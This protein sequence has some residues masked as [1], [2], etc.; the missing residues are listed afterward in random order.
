[1]DELE[2]IGRLDTKPNQTME[3]LVEKY[4]AL[5]WHI[6]SK[7]LFNEE[8]IKECV[9]DTFAEVYVH[10]AEYDA[11][12][13]SLSMWIGSISRH[14][15]ISMYR[16][17]KRDEE[18]SR[19]IASE[20]ETIPDVQDKMTEAEQAMD[21]KEA[22]AKLS[23]IDREVICMKYYDGMSISEIAESLHI[24]YETAK[25]RHTRSIKNLRK[26]LLL[27]LLLLAL[28]A[29]VACGIIF[30]Y[31]HFRVLP[32]IGITSEEDGTVYVLPEP[33]TLQKGMFTVE[34]TKAAVY[35]DFLTVAYSVSVPEQE[36]CSPAAADEGK[37]EI[38][39]YLNFHGVILH[40][41]GSDII[42]DTDRGEFADEKAEAE[43]FSKK[44]QYTL[45]LKKREL[46]KIRADEQ[47]EFLLEVQAI[48][49]DGEDYETIELPF[50]LVKTTAEKLDNYS[51]F[52]DEKT[53]GLLLNTTL[54][55]GVLSMEVYPLA[56][57]N[58][59]YYVGL[60]DDPYRQIEDDAPIAIRNEEGKV[61][62]AEPKRVPFGNQLNNYAIY[63]FNDIK[64]GKY[65]L[66]LPYVY[67]L[68]YRSGI[69]WAG[70]NL[71][72]CT[73]QE[74]KFAF[75]GGSM[76][77]TGIRESEVSDEERE[78]GICDYAWEISIRCEMQDEAMTMA[79]LP[80]MPIKYNWKILPYIEMLRGNVCSPG[81]SSSAGILDEETGEIAYRLTATDEA[82]ER[83]D[84]AHE[85]F[86]PNQ[87]GDWFCVRYERPIELEFEVK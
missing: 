84:M 21:I 72:D 16:R 23:E 64:P 46:K 79:E 62:W 22:M 53:G 44:Q 9:N 78:Y 73:F 5:V 26:L 18:F 32:E 20:I 37:R 40:L 35:Q 81:F 56:A 41:D 71:E 42:T 47:P 25:K 69:D 57:G 61:F 28:L 85:R 50:T 54:E 17:N 24:P 45:G 36:F 51:Y 13:G 87:F 27:I 12:K 59:E 43:G 58:L 14:H 75:P 31:R 29:L 63:Q 30:A 67:L 19:E 77:I 76:W 65:T 38:E 15:A 74:K 48:H 6:A 82:M 1:M 4:A 8:D 3:L 10:R 70:I 39:C 49:F 60:T 86:N 11:S 7:Y 66:S 68:L 52:Y 83:F 33:V 80:H 55:E 34:I 2:I